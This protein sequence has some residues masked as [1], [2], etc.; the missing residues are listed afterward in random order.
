MSSNIVGATS[1]CAA[2]KCALKRLQRRLG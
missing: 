2:A 1:H